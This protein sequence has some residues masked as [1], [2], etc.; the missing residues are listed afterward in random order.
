M[1]HGSSSSGDKGKGIQQFGSQPI[2]NQPF[3]IQVQTIQSQGDI[4]ALSHGR[5][6]HSIATQRLLCA[7][8][9]PFIPPIVIDHSKLYNQNLHLQVWIECHWSDWMNQLL[10]IVI[11]L[12]SVSFG[13]YWYI[14]KLRRPGYFV[15]TVRVLIKD[16]ILT[17]LQISLM[18]YSR[19]S[20]C[21]PGSL[22][23]HKILRRL[24]SYGLR[25]QKVGRLVK[26][27]KTNG[28]LRKLM[29]LGNS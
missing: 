29:F 24:I 22:V 16:L 2:T 8:A 15:K 23:Q 13:L 5:L 27:G 28:L 26:L 18:Q 3:G 17:F 1:G 4:L 11:M 7:W 25:R 20:S 14:W 10:P 19:A 9:D 12:I 6:C 21:S